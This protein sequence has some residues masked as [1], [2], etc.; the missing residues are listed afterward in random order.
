MKDVN[1][2]RVR[3]LKEF[4]YTRCKCKQAEILGV[5]EWILAGG[6][7]LLLVCCKDPNV[8]CCSFAEVRNILHILDRLSRREE[9]DVFR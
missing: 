8:M 4:M 3:I 6:W 5:K 9:T 7:W 2:E 1:I